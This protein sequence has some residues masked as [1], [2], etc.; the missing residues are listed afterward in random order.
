MKKTQR[1]LSFVLSIV[2]IISVVTVSV[3]NASAVVEIDDGDFSFVKNSDGTYSLYHYYGEDTDITLPTKA[4]GKAVT[5]IYSHAFE[6]SEITSVI[7]PEGYTSIGNSAF[8]GCSNITEIVL[9]STITSLGNMVFNSCTSLETVDLSKAVS[10]TTIPYASFQN[11]KALKS[12]TIPENIDTIENNAFSKSGLV[13][14]SI[15]NTVTTLGANVFMGC[16]DLASVTLPKG[17]TDIKTNTFSG[18]TSLVSIEIPS[19]IT[20]IGENAFNGCTLLESISLPDGLEKID[21]EAFYDCTSL[22]NLELPVTLQYIGAS[23][24]END[25]ALTELFIPASVTYIGGNAFF[26]MSIQNK[27]TITCNEDSVAETYCNE[28]FVQV[29]TVPKV[30]GDANSDGKINILDVTAIQKYKIGEQELSDYGLK[31]ADVNHDGSVTIRDATL[32]QMKLAKYDVN[33]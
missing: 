28:N 30:M 18:C 33:F 26:P 22:S 15:P 27:I 17:I 14:I 29:I 7:I 4:F 16:A 32:I 25:S 8:Y 3:L 23:A 10:L 31:C 21:N 12:F 24:F 11:D 5:S 9:P 2:M 19:K 1:I 13:S 20:E 6:D